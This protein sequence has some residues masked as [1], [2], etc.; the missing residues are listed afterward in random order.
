MRKKIGLAKLS[1]ILIEEATKRIG[2]VSTN[3][4]M[5]KDMEAMRGISKSP[6]ASWI[7]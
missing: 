2:R 5:D 6:F 7:M 4:L 3:S 1:E